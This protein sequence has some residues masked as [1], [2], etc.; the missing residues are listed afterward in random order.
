MVKKLYVVVFIGIEI[1]V[2]V[3]FSIGGFWLG[4]YGGL[5]S[6]WPPI[7]QDMSLYKSGYISGEQLGTKDGITY[8]YQKGRQ[9]QIDF[10]INNT[11]GGIK[12]VK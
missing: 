4:Y 7:N 5:N 12:W 2:I 8:W 10:L 3:I 1:I 6:L 11:A 9:G